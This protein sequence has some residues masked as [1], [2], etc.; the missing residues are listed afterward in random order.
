M[1]RSPATVRRAGTRPAAAR[2]AAV[3]R[4]AVASKPRATSAQAASTRK[5]AAGSH[6]AAARSGGARQGTPRRKAVGRKQTPASTASVQHRWRGWRLLA[7]LPLTVQAGGILVLLLATWF[8]VNTAYHV[9]R[10]PTEL[11]FP[12]EDGLYK[13][14][15]RTWSV[16]GDLFRRHSTATITPDFLA[17]LAQV[18]ASGNPVARTYWRW[19]PSTDPF[20]IYRPA[21]SAV[22]MFQFTDGTFEEARRYCIRDN[23]V[24]EDGAWN[25]PDSCWF[26]S[27]YFRVLPSHSIELTSA[28]LDRTVHGLLARYR[29]RG[30][31]LEKRQELATLVHLCGAGAGNAFARRGL[32]L[33]PGQ[34]CGAHDARAY[35]NKVARMKTVFR[36]L[37][38]R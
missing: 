11:L 21:S 33:A 31:G 13:T 28:Y 16:Y 29:L 7:A 23:R 17:A 14:P 2:T 9:V 8:V 3:K 32:Q 5:P 20:D 30:V 22:G 37:A 24:V 34:R 38:Q 10:K 4:D 6:R 15:A 25:D 12:F 26:N 19:S 27:L 18:E 35:L 36:G 1:S